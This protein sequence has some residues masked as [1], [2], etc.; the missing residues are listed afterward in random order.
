MEIADQLTGLEGKLPPDLQDASEVLHR[1]I[2]SAFG[3]ILL[4]HYF[5][6]TVIPNAKLTP[7]QAGWIPYCE[8]AALSIMTQ[9]RYATKCLFVT[10]MKNS[11]MGWD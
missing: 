7:P 9:A 10:G 1:K 6:E 11:L 5:L 8:T 2:I 4:T 3:T